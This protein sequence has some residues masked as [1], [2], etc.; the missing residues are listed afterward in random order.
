MGTMRLGFRPDVQGLRAIAVLAVVFYHAD[1]FGLTGGFVGVDV[2]FVLSGYLITALLVD[3]HR[4]NGRIALATFWARRVRRLLPASWLVI[5][6]SVVAAYLFLWPL[7]RAS[8][9]RDGVAASSYSINLWLGVNGTNYLDGGEP[10]LFQHYWSLAVEEQFYLIW[11]VVVYFLVVRRRLGRIVLPGIFAVSFVLCIYLT[12]VLQPV[13]FFMPFTRAWEFIAGAALVWATRGRDLRLPPGVVN[14]IAIASMLLLIATMFLLGAG[15][16]FPGAVAFLPVLATCGL[17]ASKGAV[18][19][20]FLSM[21]PVQYLGNISY[22]LYLWHWPVFFIFKIRFGIDLSMWQSVALFS[23]SVVLAHLTF[24]FVETPLRAPSAPVIGHRPYKVAI[25]GTLVT[26]LVASSLAVVPNFNTGPVVAVGALGPGSQDAVP[27]NI[28]PPLAQAGSS[29][30]ESYA[31]GCHLSFLES[32]PPPR[33]VYGESGSDLKIALVGDSHAAHWLPGIDAAARERGFAVY[34]F[35][36]SSCPAADV[37]VW[38]SALRR[39]YNECETWREAVISRIRDGSFAGVIVSD[40]RDYRISGG[41]VLTD[42]AGAVLRTQSR[43]GGVPLVAVSATPTF[44]YRPAYCLSGNL[45]NSAMC[46]L[47]RARVLDTSLTESEKRQ[48]IEAGVT[49]IDANEWL[50]EQDFCPV[51]R[52]RHLLYRDSHHLTVPYSASLSSEWGDVLEMIR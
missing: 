33:C 8:F 21:A 34:S 22:S 27:S 14:G 45:D 42:W 40:Y 26:A 24:R 13:A 7:E 3:E 20:P 48:L 29:N 43:L 9:W 44:P 50:C 18:L 32:A 5:A 52:G 2:F 46:G 37:T 25:A 39:D 28:E 19:T 10:S 6:A 35:T 17:L 11:P 1:L 51:M 49:Y 41:G 4:R 36:K 38:S 23:L 47:D 15:I 12:T 31:D 30:P 16:N